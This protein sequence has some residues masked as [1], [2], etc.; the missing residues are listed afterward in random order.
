MEPDAQGYAA[1]DASQ[2]EQVPQNGSEAG[3]TPER[4]E[5]EGLKA[6]MLRERSARQALEAQ[7]SNPDF[8]WTQAKSLGMTNEEAQAA[9]E[10]APLPQPAENKVKAPE[11]TWEGIDKRFA[12]RQALEKMASDDNAVQIKDHPELMSDPV[13][14]ELY[15]DSAKTMRY[16]DAAARVLLLQAKRADMAKTPEQLE[17]E[18]VEA[19][20]TKTQATT[21]K[22]SGFSAS[23]ATEV[24]EL[25]RQAANR[26][27][28]TGQKSAIQQ[29]FKRG[30]F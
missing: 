14:K 16:A 10:S 6:E 22:A 24:E 12:N 26:S 30:K 29:M 2:T 9:V 5:S 3:K 20:R 7:L 1:G 13:L 11:L 18:R 21:G 15:L 8:I 27:N 23:E 19:V 4:S 28:P 17:T 25:R